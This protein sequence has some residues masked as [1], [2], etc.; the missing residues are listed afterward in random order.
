MVNN[1][2]SE[3][4][5]E[6]FDELVEDLAGKGVTKGRIFSAPALMVGKKAI[7]CLDGEAVAFKLGRDS[8]LHAQALAL[9]GA[10]LFDPSRMKRPYKDWVLVPVAHADRWLE[11][12]A[13]SA[14][15]AGAA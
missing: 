3:R 11:F 10:S 6:L 1:D 13:N 5:L 8:E 12:A 7:A 9:D 14:P 4:T 2:V 15:S